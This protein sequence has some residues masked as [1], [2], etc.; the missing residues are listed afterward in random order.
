MA[1]SAL[2]AQLSSLARLQQLH[3][4]LIRTLRSELGALTALRALTLLRMSDCYV[5]PAS[6]AQLSWLP[7]LEVCCSGIY[8]ASNWNTAVELAG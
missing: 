3:L 4:V 7:H 8:L 1:E 2:P 6:L 5:L